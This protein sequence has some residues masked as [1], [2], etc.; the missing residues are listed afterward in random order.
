MQEESLI[1]EGSDQAVAN[2]AGGLQNVFEVSPLTD[3]EGLKG[4]GFSLSLS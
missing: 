1:L 2:S 3:D 4:L